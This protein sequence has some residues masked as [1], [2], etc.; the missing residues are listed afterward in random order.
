MIWPNLAA[1]ALDADDS[2]GFHW[3]LGD[4]ATWAL[5]VL[6][7]G[8]LIAAILAYRKQSSS[9][10]H[11]AEQVRTQSEALV[12]QRK[13][14]KALAD[15][16]K[17]QRKALEDQQAA[18]AKQAG[19]LDAQLAELS[20]RAAAAA[21]QQADA[22]TIKPGGW[23]GSVPGVRTGNGPPVHKAVVTNDSYRPIRD[24]ACCVQTEQN[25]PLHPACL[26]AR[27]VQVP[28]SPFGQ[29]PATATNLEGYI[30]GDP[31]EDPKIQLLKAGETAEF[32]FIYDVATYQGILTLRFTD[33]A[34]LCWQVDNDLHLQQFGQRDW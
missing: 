33:D 6:A 4:L 8:A 24:V 13:A 3:D 9:D 10:D 16:A 34:G 25:G 31:M 26:T 17:A 23:R 15:Q 30:L 32:V 19:M 21:R 20:Q 11:L 22:V 1:A 28:P 12:E 27:R 29:A 18:N 14:T 2:T 5:A 7:L